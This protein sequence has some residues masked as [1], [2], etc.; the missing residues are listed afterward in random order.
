MAHD[1]LGFLL[2][3]LGKFGPRGMVDPQQLIELGMQRQI[4]APDALLFRTDPQRG[5][6]A[7]I[8]AVNYR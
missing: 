7:L 3:E 1:D 2:I 8:S 4:V 6:M 5:G